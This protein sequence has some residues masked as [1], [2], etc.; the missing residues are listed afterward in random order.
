MKNV[1]NNPLGIKFGLV[2]VLILLLQIPDAMVSG[3]ISERSVRQDTV[4]DEIAQ[5]S[6]TEQRIVGPLMV[7]DYTQTRT[8]EGR[9]DSEPR[10]AFILPQSLEVRANL[11]S[12]EKYRGIYRARLYN[13]DTALQGAFDLSL[14]KAWNRGA[15]TDINVV[16]GVR[17]SRGLIRIDT[18]TLADRQVDI[19]PG[20]GLIPLAQGFRTRLDRNALDLT[21]ALTFDLR[22]LLQGMS[23]LQVTPLGQ[24]T[25]VELSS[26]WPHP[27]FIGDALPISSDVSPAG[28]RAQWTTNNVSTNI[29]PLFQDCMSDT[30]LCD[31]FNQR[32]FG[33]DLIDPVDHYLKSHRAINYSLLVMTLVFASFFLLEVLQAR[34]VHPIQ[35][36]FAGLALALF[37]LLLISLSEHTGFNWA[38]VISACASTGLL[39]VYVGGV[40]HH[41]RHGAVFG[42]SLLCLYALLFGL[43]QAEN[44]ALLMGSVLCFSV[45]TLVMVLTKNVDWYAQADPRSG[46]AHPAPPRL[47]NDDE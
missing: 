5:S 39:S 21:Q 3:L 31:E 9:T 45:L 35:Y 43:I 47:R 2:L 41:A 16:V 14:L 6:S 17:D 42:V 26:T 30:T 40:F 27:S 1:L 34:Q 36:G 7:I 8:R 25:Q 22:F 11:D 18:M 28:F 37:Y 24:S 23:K 19:I 38:Y 15:I 33:V 10:Q 12:F 44:Y 20:T 29:T 46:S 13:A 4:R 32:Q